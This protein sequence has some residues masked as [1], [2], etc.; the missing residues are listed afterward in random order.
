MINNHITYLSSIYSEIVRYNNREKTLLDIVT[1][2]KLLKGHQILEYRLNKKIGKI[3][4]PTI[5][6]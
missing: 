6:L 1:Q 4:I 3:L 5:I 2:R